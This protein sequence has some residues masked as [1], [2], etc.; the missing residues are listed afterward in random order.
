M[1]STITL[2]LAFETGSLDEL[3]HPD[4]ARLIVSEP[5]GPSRLCLP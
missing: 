4:L 5:Q 3:E 1:S 2:P